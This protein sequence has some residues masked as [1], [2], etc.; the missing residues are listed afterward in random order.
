MSFTPD[1]RLF[2]C[3]YTSQQSCADQGRELQQVHFPENVKM[4]RVVC[5]G[6]LEE[7]TLLKAFEDGADGV[8]VVGCPPDGCHNVKGS[9]RAA[10]RVQAVR[11]ALGELGVEKDRIKMFFLQ[12][13][14]HPEFVDV[15]QEMTEQITALGP[16]PF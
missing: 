2:S 13:G 4:T 7:I 16:S 9:Q 12:R 1:I 5:T 8:Y 15:A 10:K 6:K 14:L 3:H 11:S